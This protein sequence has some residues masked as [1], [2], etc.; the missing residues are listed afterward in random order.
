MKEFYWWVLVVTFILVLLGF[1][2]T[3]AMYADQRVR[4]AEIILQRA[5][6]LEKEK[7]R[8]KTRID[9]VDAN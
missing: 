2:I 1:S 8:E 6:Q 7:K 5:E 3:A 4:K 9:P